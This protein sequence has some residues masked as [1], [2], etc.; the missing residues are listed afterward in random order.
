MQFQAPQGHQASPP[1]SAGAEQRLFASMLLATLLVAGA[2]SLIRLPVVP[3]WSPVVDLLVRIVNEPPAETPA[4]AQVESEPLPP[5][6]SQAAES[7]ASPPLTMG[8]E[9]LQESRAGTDWDAMH[10]E[11]VQEYLDREVET[12]GYFNSD[13]AEKRSRL[14]ERYQPGTHEKP[15]P[16]WENV[17]LDTLGRTVLRSGDCIKVL[18]DPNVGSREVFEKFGQYMVQCT[19][20]GRYPRE[21]PWVDDIRERYEYLR[22]PGGYVEAGPGE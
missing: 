7:T 14:A 11:V 4:E 10:D 5:S 8:G 22:N 1:W 20:Q 21:L 16:I 12:Y 17:E 19:Y 2:L 15:K 18:D 9:T 6:E 13:L 3:A